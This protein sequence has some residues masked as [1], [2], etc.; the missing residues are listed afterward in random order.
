MG[1]ISVRLSEGLEQGLRRE[2][3]ARRVPVSTVIRELLDSQAPSED[4]MEDL[5]Q[6]LSRL[7]E[8]AGL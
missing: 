2:A 7:E 8:M 6:R 5:E 3:A 1:S 4:R